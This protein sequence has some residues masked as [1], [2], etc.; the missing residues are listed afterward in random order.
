[1]C[2]MLKFQHEELQIM[3]FQAAEVLKPFHIGLYASLRLPA[4]RNACLHAVHARYQRCN[5]QFE[6]LTD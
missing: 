4:N 1:M 6:S 2:Y 3:L 5:D